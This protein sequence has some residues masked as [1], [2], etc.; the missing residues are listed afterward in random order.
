[1]LKS[2]GKIIE[3]FS[4]YYLTFSLCF[5]AIVGIIRPKTIKTIGVQIFNIVWNGDVSEYIPKT[6]ANA[7]KKKHQPPKI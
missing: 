5:F 2:I 3:T 4:C 1:M 7:V 6:Q